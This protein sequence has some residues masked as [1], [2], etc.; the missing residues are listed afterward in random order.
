M[1]D[2]LQFHCNI[3]RLFIHVQHLLLLQDYLF[4]KKGDIFIFLHL[5]WNFK[6]FGF[7]KDDGWEIIELSNF[8]KVTSYGIYMLLILRP[9]DLLGFFYQT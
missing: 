8:V 5:L 7:N 4:L 6:G 1:S 2:Y 3:C 9:K